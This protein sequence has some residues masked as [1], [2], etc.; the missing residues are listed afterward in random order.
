MAPDIIAEKPEGYDTIT[1]GS[2]TSGSIASKQYSH[3]A[4]GMNG[5]TTTTTNRYLLC[6]IHITH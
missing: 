3:A 5:T 4:F 2:S 1:T 6:Y